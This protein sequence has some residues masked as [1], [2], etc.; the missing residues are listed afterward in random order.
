MDIRVPLVFKQ[1]TGGCSLRAGGHF[2]IQLVSEFSY[3]SLLLLLLT[4][5]SSP[6]LPNSEGRVLFNLF[7]S[8]RIKKP[9]ETAI[10][11]HFVPTWENL[12]LHLLSPETETALWYYGSLLID[13]PPK[14]HG[15][16]NSLLK[17]TLLHG[18]APTQLFLCFQSLHR[19]IQGT[20]RFNLFGRWVTSADL[21]AV[22]TSRCT[23]L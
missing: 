16:P 5:D 15:R 13:L 23:I 1:S 18:C 19:K 2:W 9:Q 12:C 7:W 22:L 10:S 20:F 21:I 3:T 8:Q 17:T 14:W 11:D 6:V 4:N